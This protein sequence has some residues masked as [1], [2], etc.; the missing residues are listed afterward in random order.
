MIV[1]LGSGSNNIKMGSLDSFIQRETNLRQENTRQT[2]INETVKDDTVNK[3]IC[4]VICAESMSFNLVKSPLL[5]EAYGAH[6]ELQ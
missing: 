6:W 3:E 5:Q 2:T 1:S 4:H